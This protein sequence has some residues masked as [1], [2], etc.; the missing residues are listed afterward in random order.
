MESL[1]TETIEYPGPPHRRS[2]I[3][4]CQSSIIPPRAF[5]LIELL[6]VIAIIAVLLAV[7]IPVTHMAREHGRRAVCLS[8]LRQL[9][10]AWIAYA[11]EHD[12]K[13]VYGAAYAN[14]ARGQ[15]IGST[16]VIVNGWVGDAFF[17]PRS[18]TAILESPRK[19]ALWSY[20]R[21]IDFYRCPA[22]WTGNFL[23]YTTVVAANG[24]NVIEGTY[25]LNSGGLEMTGLGVRVGQTVLK[26]TR[27]TD[28]VS[29]G[30]S[31]RAVFLD[32]AQRPDSWDFSVHYREA[33][34]DG[35]S[36]P[37]IHHGD[38]TTLSMADGH[39]EHW[40]WKGRETMTGLPRDRQTDDRGRILEVLAVRDYQP[41]TEEGLHDL[42]RLQ[43]A[44]WGR[45][46][47]STERDP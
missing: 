20:L 29:P 24:S 34:W 28:I 47:Y 38:G 8:R 13:L 46:G 17:N 44:T 26:L 35:L 6:V 37:P 39:A 5:T 27:L 2:Q 7:L 25:S 45:L 15:G 10:L 43:R 4:D 22:G 9:T 16:R 40:K 42:Q 3:I 23:T 1:D 33:K 41:Q 36:P 30:A 19:G 31:A 18:R 14:L 32:Q 21:N 12:G 11:D